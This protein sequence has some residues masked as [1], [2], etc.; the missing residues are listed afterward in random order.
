MS[1]ERTR[2][3]THQWDPTEDDEEC[4]ACGVTWGECDEPCPQRCHTCMYAWCCGNCHCCGPTARRIATEKAE[5]ADRNRERLAR[6]RGEQVTACHVCHELVADALLYG[7]QE[8][9]A[10]ETR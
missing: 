8:R 3:E 9:H 2:Y 10:R 1:G 4:I 7:H 6:E 5:Q